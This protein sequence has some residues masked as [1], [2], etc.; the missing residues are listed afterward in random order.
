MLLPLSSDWDGQG[1][2]D[3][4]GRFSGFGTLRVV[5]GGAVGGAGVVQAAG[6]AGVAAVGFP[7][8]GVALSAEPF[9][10]PIRC[11]GILHTKFGPLTEAVSCGGNRSE[12]VGIQRHTL[13]S[14]GSYV[15]RLE[16]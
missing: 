5:D 4:C 2:Y 11:K 13:W 1:E 10:S 16:N 12:S 6:A 7:G 9:S 3:A 14:S 15:Q 8:G